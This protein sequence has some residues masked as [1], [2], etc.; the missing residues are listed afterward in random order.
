MFRRRIAASVCARVLAWVLACA[1]MTGARAAEAPISAFERVMIE[2]T[3]T[4][5]YI[6]TVAM[7]M[8]VFVRKAG[9]YESTYAAKVFPYFFSSERG[10]LAITLS[11]ENLRRLEKGE[12][13]EFSGRAVNTDGGE[14]RVEGKATPAEASGGLSGKIKV[15]VFVSKRVELIFNT[16]YRFGKP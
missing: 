1:A 14:R 9:V 7:T 6:G 16:S 4:S 12:T 8:P 3:K 15:R 11:D 13:V 2:P 10:S 5:I